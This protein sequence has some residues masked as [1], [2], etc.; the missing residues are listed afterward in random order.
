MCIF[1]ILHQR[2]WLYRL[3]NL[4]IEQKPWNNYRYKPH[5]APELRS[6]LPYQVPIQNS[7]SSILTNI[8]AWSFFGRF[9][10]SCLIP[11]KVRL[12]YILRL[13]S[14]LILWDVKSQLSIKFSWKPQDIS[15]WE[16]D[17]KDKH[18]HWKSP[19]PYLGP[20]HFMQFSLHQPE[21]LNGW[22]DG[23]NDRDQSGIKGK[24]LRLSSLAKRNQICQAFGGGPVS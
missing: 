5:N 1:R 10:P 7:T 8:R 19:V 17:E 12:W 23:K 14:L 16:Q 15:K 21:R 24:S 4:G 13:F 3:I 6:L 20:S 22:R 9:F 18:Y 11:L 2:A